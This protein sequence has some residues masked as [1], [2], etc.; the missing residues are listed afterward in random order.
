MKKEAVQ[1]YTKEEAEQRLR[2]C[3]ELGGIA[4][5]IP[6]SDGK[7]TVTYIWPEE[8]SGVVEVD[9]TSSSIAEPEPAAQPVP[10]VAPP[11]V[12]RLG[13]LSA[14]FESRGGAGTIGRDST[15]GFSY[16]TYQIA[17][18][19]GTMKR[20][21]QFLEGPFPA[22]AQRLKTAGGAEGALA[23]T[24]TFKAAWKDLAGD[25]AFAKSQHEFIQATHYEPFA[26]KLQGLGLDIRNR[27]AALRDVA[28]SVA[29]QHGSGNNVFR[30]A[31]SGK[32]LS[33]MSDRDIIN[34]VY[35]ERS[36][37]D[38]YFSKSTTQVKQAVLSR[39]KRE[40]ADALAMLG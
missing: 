31:L 32:N 22:F 28:W 24:E 6:Q 26:A 29:V 4:A 23:G 13:E 2:D 19:T 38:V 21:L 11:S 36:K 33:Q 3:R 18:R 35:D 40:R 30:N 17:T 25:P 15:G 7:W 27:S 16:G 34:A 9:E 8:G 20:Y 10:V 39:F 14:K 5:M 12:E 37:V 1:G